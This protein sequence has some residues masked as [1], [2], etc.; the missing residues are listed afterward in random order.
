MTQKIKQKENIFSMYFVSYHKA[1]C[2]D[3]FR[4]NKET[5][6]GSG[7]KVGSC[8][9]IMHS[10]F[11]LLPQGPACWSVFLF[12]VVNEGGIATVFFFFFGFWGFF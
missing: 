3:V 6:T 9:Y 1:M 7:R 10:L 5:G 4:H 11:K 2:A 8:I 12:V